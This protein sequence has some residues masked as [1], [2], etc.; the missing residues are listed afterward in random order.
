MLTKKKLFTTAAA[1]LLSGLVLTGSAIAHPDNEER[2]VSQKHMKKKHREHR[3]DMGGM[4]R[5]HRAFQHLDL[6]GEQ[7]DSLKSLKES[8][9]DT[10]IAAKSSMKPL[11]KEMHELLMAEDIDEASVRNLSVQIAEKKADHMIMMASI[12]KQA[13][14]IL[15]DEQ[16]AE[17]KK[18]KE[19]RDTKMKRHH[20]KG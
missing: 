16:R 14:A 10:M 12:K 13:I 19:K 17:L 8:N 11:K 1:V 7:K 5:L 2:T 18:M 9:K 15:T 20:S 4:H 6:S 3:H